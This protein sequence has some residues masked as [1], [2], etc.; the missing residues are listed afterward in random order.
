MKAVLG[1]YFCMTD[2]SPEA[3]NTADGCP[4]RPGGGIPR[5]IAK[6]HYYLSEEANN[7]WRN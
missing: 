4:E 3:G 1:A 2:G 5:D 6:I 7:T